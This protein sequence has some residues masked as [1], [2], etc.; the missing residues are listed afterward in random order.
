MGQP[1]RAPRVL[2][3]LLLYTAVASTATAGVVPY[4]TRSAFDAAVPSALVRTVNF[5]AITAPS[6]IT[7]GSTFED[8]TFSFSLSGG[9]RLQV[10]DLFDTT[11]GPNYLGTDDSGNQDQIVAG[12]PIDL[13]FS[14]QPISGFGAYFITSDPLLTG[15]IKL[16][17]SGGTAL[18]S[19]TRE[20]TLADGGIVYFLG[21]Y[22][23][24]S[25]YST[26]QIRY[27][28]SAAGAFL[29]GMDDFR[30]VSAGVIASVP[31]PSS[32]ALAALGLFT[33]VV[34]SPLRRRGAA[35]RS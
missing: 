6:L 32:L 22:D 27:D 13:S 15:D 11:S 26:V 33:I 2:G 30:I 20:M 3:G 31:E 14:Q 18:S 25:T 23:A 24:S 12:D 19:A 9:Q 21:F 10:V 7:S 35:R 1:T 5:D 8:I 4:T 16:V 28:A 34:A 29:Y 17:T